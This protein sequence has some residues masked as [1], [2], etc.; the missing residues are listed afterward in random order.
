M[1]S[2]PI[3]YIFKR[4]GSPGNSKEEPNPDCRG[5]GSSLVKTVIDS[6]KTPNKTTSSRDSMITNQTPRFIF[7]G[8]LPKPPPVFGRLGVTGGGMTT[9]PRTFIVQMAVWPALLTVKVLIPGVQI[10]VPPG[11]PGVVEVTF[12]K[13]FA[14]W[15]PLTAVTT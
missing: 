1:A 11:V 4:V 14:L 7:Y 15:L 2:T 10:S 5:C 8:Y 9:V 6:E 12:T 3:E 13:Q